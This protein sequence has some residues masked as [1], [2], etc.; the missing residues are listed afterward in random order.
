M[1]WASTRIK[2]NAAAAFEAEHVETEEFA[3][4]K[5]EGFL[6]VLN[7]DSGLAFRSYSK[8]FGK[9]GERDVR[10]ATIEIE[11]HRGETLDGVFNNI[12]AASQSIASREAYIDG[13][14]RAAATCSTQ[15]VDGGEYEVHRKLIT[16]GG[17]VFEIRFSVLAGDAEEY[18]EAVENTL[19]RVRVK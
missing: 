13:G 10:R 18:S 15:I 16:R 1:V 19:D 14:E 4:D 3:I 5:P 9:V 2:R 17:D 11:R 6:H 7:D 12:E 8:E